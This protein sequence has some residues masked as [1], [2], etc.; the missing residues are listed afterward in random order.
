MKRL[1]A[2]I[3][4]P[5]DVESHLD[6]H[7]D[8]A[9]AAHPELRWVKPARWH[10][11]CEFMGESG[12][13]EVDRQ[14]RRWEKRARRS[15]PLRLQLAGVG[16]F[17]KTWMAKVLWVG[18]GGDV[19]SWRKLAAYGNDPHLT[20]ARTRQRTDLTGVVDE[21]LSY[22]GPAWT[23][24]QVAVIESHLG[25]AP[26]GG[27]HYEVLEAFTLGRATTGDGIDGSESDWQYSD[28]GPRRPS[29]P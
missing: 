27:P 24:E 4:L 16:T 22:A 25:G 13:H 10:V 12:P 21:L 28:E 19:E 11:T 17:P 2:A 5:S 15:M 7:V 3:L 18:L 6:G 9:R 20:L 1:F 14:L 26:D 23:A 29:Q 8:A